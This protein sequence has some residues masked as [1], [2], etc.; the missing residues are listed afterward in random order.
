MIRTT[1]TTDGLVVRGA[2]TNNVFTNT[3]AASSRTVALHTSGAPQLIDLQGGFFNNTINAG[4]NRGLST[5][6]GGTS[7]MIITGLYGNT[8]NNFAVGQ[9][10]ELNIVAGQTYIYPG[11]GNSADA[12][13]LLAANSL[14]GGNIT[15]GATITYYFLNAGP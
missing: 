10:I 2:I 7:P 13:G 4:G 15:V 8:F 1:S 3:G 9:A 6:G 12:A 11:Q 14:A 5:T